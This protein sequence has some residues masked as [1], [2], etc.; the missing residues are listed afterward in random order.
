MSAAPASGSAMIKAV[1]GA[2]SGREWTAYKDKV[3]PS[4]P[5]TPD[6]ANIENDELYH[7]GA[8]SSG[9]RLSHVPQKKDKQKNTDM[10]LVNGIEMMDSAF[11]T[12]KAPS[13]KKDLHKRRIQAIDLNQDEGVQAEEQLIMDLV[14]IGEDTAGF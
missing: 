1:T 13:T 8:L 3:E 2:K 4:V 6:E 5:S 12:E 14:G 9:T 7:D 10:D 11:N